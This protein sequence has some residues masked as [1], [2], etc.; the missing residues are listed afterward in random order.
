MKVFL[1]HFVGPNPGMLI[2]GFNLLDKEVTNVQVRPSAMDPQNSWT[3]AI[4]YEHALLAT[5]EMPKHTL[6]LADEVNL[7]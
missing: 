7:L 6:I 2:R 4:H 5:I 3:L 1:H